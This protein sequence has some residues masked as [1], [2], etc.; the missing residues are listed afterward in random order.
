[1]IKKSEARSPIDF[2][3][4][5]RIRER[6]TMLGLTQGQFG[7]R[8]GVTCQQVLKYERGTNR[9]SAGR[10]YVIA[11]ELGV[12]LESFFEGIEQNDGRPPRRGHRLLDTMRNVG[13]IKEEDRLEALGLLVRALAGA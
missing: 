10:L 3:V 2:F 6:R 11:R 13:E 7:D 4:G 12:P 5:L 8:I 1:M 9:V